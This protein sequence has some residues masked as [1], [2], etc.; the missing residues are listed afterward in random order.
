MKNRGS[1]K[2]EEIKQ[3]IAAHHDAEDIEIRAGRVVEVRDIGDIETIRNEARAWC[4]GVDIDDI[5]L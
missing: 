3:Y 1:G 4:R 5:E 2:T